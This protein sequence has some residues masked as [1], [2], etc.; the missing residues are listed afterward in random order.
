MSYHPMTA[1]APRHQVDQEGLSELMSDRLLASS[2]EQGF[3][4]L[5]TEVIDDGQGIAPEKL[6]DLFSM[7]SRSSSIA[8]HGVG[9]GLTSAK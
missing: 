4:F 9:L 8:N 3:G 7:F 1:V 2:V 5:M 6:E